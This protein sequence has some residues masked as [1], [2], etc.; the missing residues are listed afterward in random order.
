MKTQDNLSYG[1]THGEIQNVKR[2]QVFMS[3]QFTGVPPSRKDQRTFCQGSLV[4]TGEGCSE[5]NWLP[6]LSL[7]LKL[8]M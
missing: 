3:N 7:T 1:F 5:V 8:I 6:L 2:E 4:V